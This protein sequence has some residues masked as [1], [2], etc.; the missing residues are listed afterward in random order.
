MA[1]SGERFA[2]QLHGLALWW[3]NQVRAMRALD[4]LNRSPHAELQRTAS[5]LGVTV[6]RL[7]QVAARGPLNSLLID[8]MAMAYGLDLRHA[9]LN[10]VREM[11]ER[12][13]FC[14][15]R[16]RCARDLSAD[17]GAVRAGAYCANV[18]MLEALGRRHGR[19]ATC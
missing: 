5:D 7:K 17:D 6:Q 16:F 11:E 15:S 19:L 8:K 9:N 3:R 10:T 4:E 12:C 2:R 18:P 13:T 14:D 1:A